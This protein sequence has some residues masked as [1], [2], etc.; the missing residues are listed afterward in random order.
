MIESLLNDFAMKIETA[1]WAAPLLALTAGILTSLSPCSLTAIPLIIGYVGGTA[2]KNTKRGLF[3]SVVFAAGTAVTFLVLGMIAALAGRLLGNNSS[4]WSFLMGTLMIL[5]AFQMWGVINLIPSF[6]LLTKNKARGTLGAFVSGLLA[7][8]FSSPCSTPVLVVLLALV[9]N[10]ESVIWGLVLML[11]YAIGH[12]VLII[13]AG[14]SVPFIR[15]INA[16]DRYRRFGSVVKITIG[17]VMAAIGFYMF[18][19][20]F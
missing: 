20:A 15:K 19:M 16:S 10:Q 12:S 13:A 5:M 6:H 8:F 3:Y 18:W 17:A 9:A 14:T 7:G 4:L 11:L 1:V 2:E